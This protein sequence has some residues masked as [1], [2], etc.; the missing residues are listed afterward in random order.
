MLYIYDILL[1]WCRDKLYDFFEWE[2]TDKLEHVKKIPLI[3]VERGLINK[4]ST[5]TI[6][7]DESFPSK[8][9]NLTEIYNSKNVTKVPYAI[10]LTDGLSALAIKLDKSG[11]IKFRSKLLVDEEEEILCF[12]NRLDKYK[13]K[14]TEKPGNTIEDFTT[15]NEK[16]I[17]T[18]L[19]NDIETT[20][21]KKD[22]EKLKYLY[23]EYCGITTNNMELIYNNLIESIH[24]EINS[25]HIK[26]YNLLQL[27]GNKN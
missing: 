9:Y 26:I 3:R 14:Y 16:K 7:L 10:L 1:N 12:C 20:Y 24:Y 8:I 17:R 6:K 27:I 4:L 25:G 19:L 11:N 18:F 2:K 5:E 15:R 21:K 22:Y 13:L 23:N